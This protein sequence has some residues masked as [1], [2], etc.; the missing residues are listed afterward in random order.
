MHQLI[1]LISLIVRALENKIIII[2][3]IYRETAF[4]LN[5]LSVFRKEKDYYNSTYLVEL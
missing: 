5:V 2:T 3:N 1:S 4:N